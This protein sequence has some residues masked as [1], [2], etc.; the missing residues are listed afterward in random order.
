MTT[1]DTHI[2]HLDKEYDNLNEEL[3]KGETSKYDETSFTQNYLIS[4]DVQLE[5]Y[6]WVARAPQ[7]V[8][9]CPGG[10]E[11]ERLCAW[12][13]V[14]KSFSSTD[15]GPNPAILLLRCTRA[16]AAEQK[17]KPKPRQCAH[18]T[19]SYSRFTVPFAHCMILFLHEQTVFEE[20]EAILGEEG[21]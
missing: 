12:Y 15:L 3:A 14:L 13:S 8:G 6:N 21:S 10:Y 1:L 20:I 7:V 17:V 16:T 2:G 11:Q 5:L 4:A 19:P 9:D 18:F